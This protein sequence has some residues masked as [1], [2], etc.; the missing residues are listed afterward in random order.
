MALYLNGSKISNSLIIGGVAEKF[1]AIHSGKIYLRD[2]TIVADNDYYY[3]DLFDAP[4]GKLI[5]D[6]GE[7]AST[8]D[9]I[10]VEMCASDGSNVN[11]WSASNRFREVNHAQYYS[12]APKLRLSFRATYLDDIF[13]SYEVG[14]KIYSNYDF[15]RVGNLSGGGGGTFAPIFSET[16]LVDNSSL[17]S[18]FTFSEDYH[19][20]D[21]LKFNLYNQGYDRHTYQ[22]MTP[23]QVDILFSITSRICFDEFSSNQAINYTQSG[24]TWTRVWQRNVDIYEVVGLTCTNATMTETEIYKATSVSGTNVTVTTQEDLISFDWIMFAANDSDYD[25]ILPCQHIFTPSRS[26]YNAAGDLPYPFNIYNSSWWIAI[27]NHAI[28]AG[29]YLYVIGIKFTPT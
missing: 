13:V 12:Q 3:T 1:I 9:Y 21:L 18:S 22:Y 25:E 4:N 29:P 7:T 28:S 5:F 27:G 2:G 6:L 14:N 8:S 16:V 19:N 23:N 11:Y 26:L 17:A 15:C 10:G 20:Y 24:L